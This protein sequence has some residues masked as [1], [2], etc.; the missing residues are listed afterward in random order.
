MLAKIVK[1][2]SRLMQTLQA[3]PQLIRL[4]A[5]LPAIGLAPLPHPAEPILLS[6]SFLKLFIP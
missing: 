6:S 5:K 4:S 1:L 2:I 3:R